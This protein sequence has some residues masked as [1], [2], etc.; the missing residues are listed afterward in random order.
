MK[1]FLFASLFLCALFAKPVFAQDEVTNDELYKYAVV[2]ET[3]D[4]FQ[5][6]LSAQIT[7][8]VESQPSE[9][10]NRYNA[11]AGGE[12]PGNDAEKQ[13]I[14]Q[15]NSMKGERTSEFTDAY[16]TLIKRVL[17]AQSYAKVKKAVANDSDVKQRYSTI[18]T[19][20]QAAKDEA[21]A[22]TGQ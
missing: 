13:F 12:T 20:M 16:K 19:A 11:L 6:E 8:Y 2:Q 4:L 1:K 14:D 10:K 3:L 5:S 18:V 15:V 17:G 7:E 22:S 9:I 21:S